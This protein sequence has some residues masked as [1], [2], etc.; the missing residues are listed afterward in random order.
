MAFH[1]LITKKAE[2]N[3]DNLP[4]SYRLKIRNVLRDLL[5][6]PFRGKKLSGKKNGQYSIAVWPYRIIYFVI[7]RELI[8]IVINI[9][10]RQGVYK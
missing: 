5:I 2:K 4:E 9:G 7:K 8:I 6:D 3:L 10:H 1:L